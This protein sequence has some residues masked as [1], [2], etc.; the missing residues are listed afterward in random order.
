MAKFEPRNK[1]NLSN[2]DAME[3]LS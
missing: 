1:S 3:K 2:N